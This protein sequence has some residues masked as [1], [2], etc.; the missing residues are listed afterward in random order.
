MIN[1]IL[2]YI[3]DLRIQTELL[4]ALNWDEELMADFMDELKAMLLASPPNVDKAIF[5]LKNT[6]WDCF[7][8][9]VLPEPVA[10]AMEK[11]IR[12]TELTIMKEISAKK[13]QLYALPNLTQKNND[14]EWN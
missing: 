13:K 10:V 4:E 3:D 5:W 7:D 12:K 11:S 6:P 2:G 8:G 14:P 1:L 9:A